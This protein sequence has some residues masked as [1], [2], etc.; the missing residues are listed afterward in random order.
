MLDNFKVRIEKVEFNNGVTVYVKELTAH[1]K[2]ILDSKVVKDYKTGEID[3]VDYRAKMLACSLCNEKGERLFSD[4]DFGKISDLPDSVVNV[5]F[6][7]AKELNTVD[8]DFF[9]RNS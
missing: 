7:K 3:I 8:K 6:E 1:E 5:L 2:D 9:L 4:E